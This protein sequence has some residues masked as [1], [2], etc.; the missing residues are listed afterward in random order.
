MASMMAIRGGLIGPKSG[1]VEK[2]SV[3][4]LLFEGSRAA[5]VRQE[6]EVTG[7]PGRFDVEKVISFIKNA[8]CL[9]SELCFLCGRGWHFQKNHETKLSKS[10][11]WS[12]N[13]GGDV[14]ISAK[15]GRIHGDIIKRML[16]T[17]FKSPKEAT[18]S[19]NAHICNVFW[20][21]AW[22]AWGG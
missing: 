18:C 19:R 12:P 14:K 22:E 4:P 21:P 3:L 10:E 11:K 5:K 7:E 15:W 13:H 20:G 2:A 1:N 17:S 6:H 16:D 9:Y 8:L